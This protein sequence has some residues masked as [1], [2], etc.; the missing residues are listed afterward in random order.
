MVAVRGYKNDLNQCLYAMLHAHNTGSA[1]R[2]A[3]AIQILSY[4]SF[5]K[6]FPSKEKKFALAMN[7]IFL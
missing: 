3:S 1:F 7:P 5:I 6:F 4:S 2:S